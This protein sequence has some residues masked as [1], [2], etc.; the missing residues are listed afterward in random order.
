[1]LLCS[2]LGLQFAHA[3]CDLSTLNFQ[4][5]QRED[6]GIDSDVTSRGYRSS[7]EEELRP[8]CDSIPDGDTR[9]NENDRSLSSS[10]SVNE[11]LS[12][13]VFVELDIIR[14]NL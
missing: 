3:K 11:R 1:M 5:L 9:I 12:E 2:F 6:S 4:E 7:S 10:P 8:M 14:N 13:E